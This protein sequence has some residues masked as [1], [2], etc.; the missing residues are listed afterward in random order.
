MDLTFDELIPNG[1]KKPDS[2]N[3]KARAASKDLS[4]DELIPAKGALPAAAPPVAAP[5][6]GPTLD[7]IELGK[8][9][10]GGAWEQIKRGAGELNPFAPARHEQPSGILG[11]IVGPGYAQT[12]RGIA[13]IV[14][15][16]LSPLS[17]PFE[18]AG[19]VAERGASAAF[20]GQRIVRSED[21]QK[22]IESG[23]APGRASPGFLGA[24]MRLRGP[25]PPGP[26]GAGAEPPRPGAEPPPQPT[27]ETPPP[28]GEPSRG[29]GTTTGERN[30]I[31]DQ[32]NVPAPPGM[33]A[34]RAPGG[35]QVPG[36]GAET[37]PPTKL[38]KLAPPSARAPH[39]PD[40]EKPVSSSELSAASRLASEGTVNRHVL[41]DLEGI[42]YRR[43][44]R[45]D[46]VRI[47]TNNDLRRLG[48]DVVGSDMDRR[49][50]GQ[51][52]GDASIS[53]T[54]EEQAFRDKEIKPWLEGN[55][56]LWQSIVRTMK[57]GVKPALTPE[58]ANELEHLNPDYMHRIT[59]DSADRL[60]GRSTDVTGE[61]I[62]VGGG[63]RAVRPGFGAAPATKPRRF[64]SAEGTN[65][66][67]S[68]V[69][70]KKGKVYKFDRSEGAEPGER[71]KIGDLP[72]GAKGEAGNVFVS[73]NGTKYKLGT[74][75]TKD[76]E[77]ETGTQYVKSALVSTRLNRIQLQ[78][79]YDSIRA[80]KEFENYARKHGLASG[81]PG[82]GFIHTKFPQLGH[83]YF[84]PRVAK[85][86][87]ALAPKI[88]EG[89]DSLGFFARISQT[90][91]SSLF[92]NPVVHAGN[93]V[94]HA[95]YERGW[96]NFNPLSYGRYGKA[97]AR[98]AKATWTQ[99]KDFQ[100]LISEGGALQYGK[101]LANRELS[102]R[103][104]SN[105]A[106]LQRS[107]E[108]K[109]LL[110]RWEKLTG[111]PPISMI[112]T[113][114]KYSGD[115]L[116]IAGDTLTAAAFYERQLAHGEEILAKSIAKVHKDIPSYRNPI[117]KILPGQA[118]RTIGDIT[119][120]NA[121]RA[122][123]NFM[124]YHENIIRGFT[125]MFD[126]MAQGVKHMGDTEARADA[127]EAVGKA[128]ALGGGFLLYTIY[129]DRAAQSA[130]GNEQAE[131]FRFGP[132]G[133]M[134]LAMDAMTD[135]KLN[136]GAITRLA[137]GGMFSPSPLLELGANVYG[138]NAYRMAPIYNPNLTKKEE[139]ERYK[140]GGAGVPWKER[141][142]TMFGSAV[143]PIQRALE[144]YRSKPSE[145]PSQLG[146]LAGVTSFKRRS[147]KPK[148]SGD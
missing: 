50:Y 148:Y 121:T 136:P 115:A 56:E 68:I 29:P 5:A 45:E 98:A 122:F 108:G 85:H 128:V 4:F 48:P 73:K 33:A 7:P 105:I 37:V 36:A 58:L 11:R 82:K 110:K 61:S 63:P 47:E 62:D 133:I 86:L 3:N 43:Q 53:L 39:E 76:I 135:K 141:L 28:A 67:K 102:D 9:R 130:T 119:R 99:N 6:P 72:K 18:Y 41:H 91:T 87:D 42:E 30:V 44:G 127:R 123:N 101:R 19:N 46:A 20:P 116:W 144:I 40:V 84:N 97:L 95:F 96:R 10:L 109:G 52:E 106:E 23:L 89:E 59:V 104:F 34:G 129:G 8:E 107:E 117:E 31:K 147:E 134:Q 12:G 79:M 2:S 21:V 112:R 75:L 27:P 94:A 49:L 124:P 13:D 25:E 70:V 16:A 22:A 78:K 35:D 131:A 140:E 74:A 125:N 120:Q 55:K 111:I 93:V 145:I 60:L 80:T 57:G 69:Y 139:Y 90:L 81:V 137:T 100:E 65:G 17:A 118:G 66:E 143:N 32:S 142:E 92:F 114:Y 14:S 64:F 1:K 146:H 54:P 88:K 77:A 26:P 138:Y 113:L 38:G 24:K 103:M 83:L 15:G 126:D 71:R 51:G 132:F